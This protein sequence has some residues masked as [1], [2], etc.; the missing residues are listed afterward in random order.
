MNCS[1]CVCVYVILCG[2]AGNR[3]AAVLNRSYAEESINFLG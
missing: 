3:H 1:V 2:M